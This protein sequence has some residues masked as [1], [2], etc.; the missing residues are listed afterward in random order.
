MKKLLSSIFFLAV[1]LGAVAQSSTTIHI[2]PAT[3]YQTIRSFGASDC[4]T[5]DYVGRY[6]SDTEKEKAAR[7]LFSADTDAN[8]NPQGISLS[9]WRVNLGAG[10]STQGNNSNIADKTR[11]TDCFLVPMAGRM[12]G[13]MRK[14]NSGSCRKPRAMACRSSCFSPMLR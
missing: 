10:S 3:T 2:Q 8:G 7:W 1:T 14:D 12:T 11:R 9:Q 13:P 5:A 6:F 4:W